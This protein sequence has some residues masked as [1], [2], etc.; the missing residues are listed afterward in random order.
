MPKLTE[1]QLLVLQQ[2]ATGLSFKGVA[3]KLGM[4]VQSVYQTMGRI[5]ERLDLDIEPMVSKRTA[6]VLWYLQWYVRC[7]KC[8]LAG[9]FFRDQN[10]QLPR[11][12][13]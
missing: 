12:R 2:A 10:V 9:D 11:L 1:H 8:G 3:E 6:A 7:D 13:R 5:Y 4:D